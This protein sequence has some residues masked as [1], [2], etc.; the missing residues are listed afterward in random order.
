MLDSSLSFDRRHQLDRLSRAPR[1]DL[2]IIGGGSSGLG[3]AFEAVARGLSVALIER[4]DFASG[5][6]S[7]SSKLLHGGV[8]YLAQG[9]IGLVREALHERQSILSLAPHLSSPLS[10]VMPSYRLWQTPF[11]GAGLTVYDWLAGP[12]S[13]GSTRLLGR[14]RLLEQAPGCK[15]DGLRG[16]CLYWDAQFDDAR[17]ALGLARTAAAQGA[18]MLNYCAA[19][20]LLRDEDGRVSGVFFV[21]SETN[22]RHVIHAGCVLDAT[23]SFAGRLEAPEP[24]S[25]RSRP[26]QGAH[27]VL[28][29][30]FFP[31][32]SA[33][34]IPK[35]S[36]GRVLFAI[37]WMGKLVVGTTDTPREKPEAEPLPLSEEIDF[38][39]REAAAYFRK[40]PS[41]SDIQ[42][43][44]AGQRPLVEAQDSGGS[45]GSVSR[46]HSIWFSSSGLAH[47]AG[48]KWTTFR[49]MARDTLSACADRGLLPFSARAEASLA[50]LGSEGASRSLIRE[51]PSLS[52]YGSEADQ[53]LSCSKPGD[54]EIIG[55]I[56]PAMVRFAARHEMARRVSDVLA[57][58]SRLLFLSADL[59]I[60]A[61]PEVAHLL[62]EETR[63][64]P[65]LDDFL[66]MARSFLAPSRSG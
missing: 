60:R 30:S 17:L 63:E 65:H 36:D 51:A 59:A 44:W 39:L 40:A 4:L 21:D 25:P 41:R 50:L 1:F 54:Q 33:L 62:F 11:Y 46:E 34:L 9:R 2:A 31:G 61:A 19:E 47:L 16:G 35:T 53:V 12:A 48:G 66:R 6:T 37:P 27:L 7:R 38:I 29:A 8:R 14:D 64:D 32:E 28:D 57:R 5:A 15:P 23:G 49:A 20:G 22:R 52:L 55:G 56:L 58:R 45:T 26:S 43:A 3:V 18:V 10:F 24:G 42:S 13:L